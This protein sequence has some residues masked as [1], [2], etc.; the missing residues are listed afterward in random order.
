LTFTR[1]RALMKSISSLSI[2]EIADEI[3]KAVK[4]KAV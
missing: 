3:I 4:K 1:K 2:Q